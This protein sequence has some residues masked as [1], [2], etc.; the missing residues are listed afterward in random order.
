MEAAYANLVNA[1]RTVHILQSKDKR[2][3]KRGGGAEYERRRKR[4]GV[5]AHSSADLFDNDSGSSGG[6]LKAS[7][8]KRSKLTNFAVS[9]KWDTAITREAALS[10]LY[11][12]PHTW[13]VTLQ[14]GDMLYLPAYYYHSVHSIGDDANDS[15]AGASTGGGSSVSLNLW[16]PSDAVEA[17]TQLQMCPL[18]YA[19]EATRGERQKGGEKDEDK[20]LSQRFTSLSRA[21]QA[22]YR[23]IAADD[24]PAS[25][26]TRG[27][28]IYGQGAVP[29]LKASLIARHGIS[30]MPAVSESESSR[31]QGCPGD[32]RTKL[33]LC[34]AAAPV[35]ATKDKD[36]DKGTQK[37]A[38]TDRDIDEAVECAMVALSPLVEDK[39]N[40]AVAALLL[41]DYIDEVFTLV[42]AQVGASSPEAM[43]TFVEE[44]F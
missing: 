24:S 6:T 12:L 1:R 2:V 17:F 41:M 30:S 32:I 34:P 31:T 42:A 28:P 13:E 36:K 38:D 43:A 7:N 5:G 29:E 37:E 18:P 11:S 19:L 21:A 23:M 39:E 15:T 33:P 27:D 10:G 26:A 14:P 9:E 25:K 8:S 40:K 35:R 16:V 44:C 20:V 3:G 22:I 4:H